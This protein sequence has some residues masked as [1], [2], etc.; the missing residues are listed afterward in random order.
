MTKK[1]V[2]ILIPIV[3]VIVGIGIR[4]VAAPPQQQNETLKKITIAGMPHS[5]TGFTIFVALDRGFF[6]DEGLDVALE[7]AYPHGTAILEAVSKGQADLGASS[8]TPFM[9]A[10]LSGKDLCSIVSMFSGGKHL[11]IVARGDR[12]IHAVEDLK[13]KLIGVTL[14]T[15]GEYFLDTVLLFNGISREHIHTVDLKPSEMFT[16]IVSGRVDAIATWNPIMHKVWLKLGEAARVF[17]A[18]GMYTVSFLLSARREYTREN[19]RILEKT[20]RALLRSSDFIQSD[21]AA[22][23]DIVARYLEI[24]ESILE[25]LS[26]VYHFRSSLD[27]AL[28]VS[29]ENEAKWAIARKLT[30]RTEIPNFLDFVYTNALDAVAPQAVTIIK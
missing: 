20:V 28:V 17:Y 9:H 15:N 29:L 30:D 3:V 16:S 12:G 5:F 24:D 27:Q 2:P 6:H 18:D 10:V 11:G 25:E 14:G 22:S 1:L 23:R 4:L 7:T 13:G 19:Q 26:G 8:E 21:P